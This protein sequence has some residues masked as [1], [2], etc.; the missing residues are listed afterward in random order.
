[1]QKELSD[2]RAVPEEIV[3][4]LANI[5]AAVIPQLFHVEQLARDLLMV[6]ELAMHAH[7]DDFFV[8]RAV[9][10][11]EP[12]TLRKRFDAPPQ[13][14][15]VEILEIGHRLNPMRQRL[16]RA[17]FV[18]GRQI[19]A[20]IGI[21]ILQS[22]S[23]PVVD[24]IRSGEATCAFN[25]IRHVLNLLSKRHRQQPENAE[26]ADQTGDDCGERISDEVAILGCMWHERPRR[27]ADH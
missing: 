1:V 27:R 11:A 3:L 14:V 2:E 23:L 16:L 20:V 15:V 9:R 8:V 25:E 7:H 19:T 6:P 22:E 5:S 26:Q 18:L 24:P 17:R 12:A 10:D 4:E 21:D 13:V